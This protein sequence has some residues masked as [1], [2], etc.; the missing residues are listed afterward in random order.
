MENDSAEVPEFELRALTPE[1]SLAHSLASGWWSEQRQ[2]DS[3]CVELPSSGADHHRTEEHR[4]EA[5]P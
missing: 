3:K 4:T 2:F 5:C 1:C